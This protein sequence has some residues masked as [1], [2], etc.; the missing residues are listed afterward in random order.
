MIAIRAAVPEDADAIAAIYA[1]HVLVGTASFEE[2][3]PDAREM[4]ERITA[5]AGRF[6]WLVATQGEA[7]GGVLAYAYATAFHTRPAYRWAVETTVYVADAAQRQGAGRLLYQVLI[8]TLT[9]QGFTQAIARIALPNNASIA[10]HE[11]VGFRRAG[12]QRAVGYKRGQWIDV[13]LWQRALAEHLAS[14]AEPRVFAEVG[15]VRG[16]RLP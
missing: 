10:L 6:P 12:V 16:Y 14:P 1:P 3:A 4:A 13:G 9:A 5:G 8:D 7:A 2:Q 11:A 15:V